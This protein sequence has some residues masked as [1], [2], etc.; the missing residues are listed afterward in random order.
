MVYKLAFTAP[1]FSPGIFPKLPQSMRNEI[2][3]KL[4]LSINDLI[5]ELLNEY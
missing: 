5:K 4:N 1:L 2:R 3:G